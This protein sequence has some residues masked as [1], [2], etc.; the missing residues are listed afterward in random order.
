MLAK[1]RDRI[2]QALH[3]DLGQSF[4]LLS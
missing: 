2:A 4:S 1:E 3:D